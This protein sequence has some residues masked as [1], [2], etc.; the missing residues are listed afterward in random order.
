MAD[1]LG[2]RLRDVSLEE[3]IRWFF[4]PPSI[5]VVRLPAG[6]SV[7]CGDHPGRSVSVRRAEDA[8]AAADFVGDVQVAER[9]KGDGAGSAQP[10]TG[11]GGQK[12][13][14]VQD[15]ESVH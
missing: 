11:D 4:F 6:Y 2:K 5:R 13:V 12:H 9:I 3:H 8:D 10:S 14:T 15:T 7:R 1:P